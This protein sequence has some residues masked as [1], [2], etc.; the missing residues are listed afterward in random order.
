MRT[1][2]LR[3]IIPTQQGLPRP[4][5]RARDSTGHRWLIGLVVFSLLG[6]A[7]LGVVVLSQNSDIN[8]LRPAVTS[9]ANSS[10][11]LADQVRS[12]GQEPVVTP[13]QISG[14]AGAAGE[15]GAA[16]PQGLPGLTGPAGPT[17]N[18][19]ATGPQGVPGVPG[20]PG[21]AG[22]PGVDGTQGVA[23]TDGTNG[24]NGATGPQGDTGP[25]GPT[26]PQG[27]RGE[28]G[29]QGS[30]PAGFTFT[31]G[32]GQM[33]TCTRDPGSP[34]NA[35]TYTCSVAAPGTSSTVPTGFRLL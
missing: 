28:Q 34:D 23:G 25:A 19:G 20:V 26:G 7:G 31:D 9:L 2:Q 16:G 15:Q 27:D 11:A 1:S 22:A 33:Q 32:L 13:E 21:V 4:A 14:P 18:P 17:G 30:P 12:L 24:T 35:A 10:T 5:A 29:A 6:T 8:E 3:S